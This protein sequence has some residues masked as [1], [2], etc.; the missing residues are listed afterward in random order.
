MYVTTTWKLE[1]NAATKIEEIKR[2][3]TH[4]QPHTPDL[5]DTNQNLPMDVT[6]LCLS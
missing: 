1:A 6:E 4:W 2:F 5:Q 3:C